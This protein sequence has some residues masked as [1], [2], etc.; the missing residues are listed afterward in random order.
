MPTAPRNPFK[1]LARWAPIG[2]AILAL[3]AC[4][5]PAPAPDNT[6]APATTAPATTEPATTAAPANQTPTAASPSTS[7][8]PRLPTPELPTDRPLR[9]GL[10]IVDGVYNTELVAPWDIF[11]HTD[12]P[13]IEVF[14]ISPDGGPVTTYEGMVVQP[15]YG[16]HDAP[17]IDILV[18]PSADNSR[19]SDLEN[20]TL[21][22]FVAKRG[23]QARYVVSFCWGAFVLAEA[24]LLDGHAA[25]TFPPDIQALG[26]R[27]PALDAQEG[28][29]FVHH[30]KT[31]TSH[32]GVE[33]F[34]AA[35]YLVDHLFGQ[36]QAQR[37]AGGLLVPWPPPAGEL[38][39]LVVE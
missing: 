8:W 38:A 18:V 11:D 15:R 24:G 14:A 19:G 6:T 21:I 27:Y 5:G 7:P 25:T 39:G 32:G 35:L 33:S 16:F 13:G 31:L 2:Y 9:A 23:Q 12:P 1:A 4:G 26:Q 36:D 29:S 34:E 17:E 37:I 28:Y 20:Q 30:G 10:V 22:D 3:L